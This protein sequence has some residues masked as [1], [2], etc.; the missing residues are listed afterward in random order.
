MRALQLATSQPLGFFVQSI[1]TAVVALGVAY[2]TA[3]SL[4][5]VI[6]AAVPFAAVILFWISARMQSSI[7][8]QD[9]EL[10]KASKQANNAISAIDTVKCFNGQDTEISQY[11]KAV[12][13]AAA[14]YLI[15]AQ[16]V[17]LQIGTARFV[18]LGMFVQGFWYGSHLV[19]AGTKS[20][21]QV[22]TAF[23]ACLLATQAID[24]ILPQMMVLEKG[25]AAGAAPKSILTQSESGRET[26]RLIDHTT[27]EYCDGDIELRDVSCSE[28]LFEHWLIAQI[29]FAYPTRQNQPVLQN[30]SFFFPAGET[31]YVVGKSGSGKSTLGYLLLHF[32]EPN[33]GD[34]LI[35][36]HHIQ[37]LNVNWLRKNIT[38]FQQQSVL[39]NETIFKNIAFG[40]E[41]HGR[42]RKEEIRQAIE[43]A[44]L[45]CTMDDLPQGLDTI[46]GVNGTGMSGSQAQRVDIARARL[47]D[48]PVLILDEA[49]SML[50]HISKRLILEQIQRWRRGK[51]TI[52]VTHDFSEIQENKYV[53]VLDKGVIVQEGFRNVLEKADSGPFGIPVHNIPP[54]DSHQTHHTSLN[55]V[56]EIS[57]VSPLASAPIPEKSM[58]SSVF[59]PPSDWQ[60]LRRSSLSLAPPLSALPSL[61]IV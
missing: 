59:R 45:Q 50:D 21:G 5:L 51:T 30:A 14:F 39:F 56:D 18:M 53:Y 28:L 27:P 34:L 4:A 7:D 32:Y 33:S 36:G 47:R 40:R 24:E 1:V 19:M 11:V 42:L 26:R 12:K 46:V 17:A 3:W 44:Q 54:K 13:S 52:I 57:P 58:L 8:S 20:A 61:E 60:Q 31:T 43:T 35:D 15:Q 55:V 37:M 9:C 23:W 10:T 48:T 49:T 25:R 29:T 41:N 2:Y 16:S 38:L 22:L 6:L